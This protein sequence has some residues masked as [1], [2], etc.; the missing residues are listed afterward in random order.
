M[1]VLVHIGYSPWSW[2][3]RAAF[4][5]AN[6][7]HTPEPYIPGLSE[8]R[9]RWRLGQWTGPVSVPVLFPEGEAPVQG[10]F[11][12]ATW[13]NRRQPIFPAERADEVRR[14]TDLGDGA[15]SAG[16]A[17][18]TRRVLHAP[19]ALKESLPPPIR[20]LGPIGMA[21]GRQACHQLLSKYGGA[22]APDEVHADRLR[23]HLRT[24]REG[25]GGKEWLLGD[26]SWTDASA[27]IALHFVDPPAQAPI[28]PASRVCW[29]Q[30]AIAAEFPD[31][32][33]WRER[34]IARVNA[35]R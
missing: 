8:P 23:A 13:V 35:H 16:R 11:D 21:I 20:S 31:L 29:T 6:I 2:R 30:P 14:W 1:P 7:P 9:L 18:T 26:F 15:A 34:T 24:L 17:L 32:L 28:G 3:A 22:A 12:I 25:L 33:A 27:A 10:G 19:D 4:K 5:L